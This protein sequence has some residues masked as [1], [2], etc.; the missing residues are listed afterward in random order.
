[1]RTILQSGLAL[2]WAQDV[3]LVGDACEKSYYGG[4]WRL[5]ACAPNRRVSR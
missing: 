3:S 1:M 4:G 5:R 2:P